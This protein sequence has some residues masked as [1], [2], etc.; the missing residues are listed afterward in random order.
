RRTPI[1]RT[2]RAASDLLV[3][4]GHF[5]IRIELVGT[6]ADLGCHLPRIA[7]LLL[8][9]AGYPLALLGLLKPGLRFL[10]KLLRL[11]P[12]LRLLAA[13]H[14]PEPDQA[15]NE[16]RADRNHDRSEEHTSELQSPA[17]LPTRSL[18][19]AL[20]IY[21]GCHL[22]RIA[23]LL[24]LLAGYP[25]ALLGLLKPGL[26]FLTKLLRLFPP[27]RLL[28]AAHHPEPDQAENEQRAD[29]NHD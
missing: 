27:L 23:R 6:R 16:Q 11:F 2:A 29:R 8:L 22:P 9:L 3:V 14:H 25:L 17:R 28:A 1:G 26:R 24:L 15:E 10:T 21:L 13:A 5:P 18:H 4:V 12:P 7:R 19:V 20:P